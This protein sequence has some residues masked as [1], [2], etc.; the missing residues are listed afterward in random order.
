MDTIAHIL[1]RFED[2]KA[3]RAPFDGDWNSIRDFVRP[4]SVAFNQTTGQFTAVRPET[5]FDG[6]ACNA[7]EELASALHTYMT[8]PAERWFEL[9]PPE[10]FPFG[11]DGVE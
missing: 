5:M 8:N 6:T 4:I 1:N 10:L 3:K 7:L 2:A 11:Q 9:Q